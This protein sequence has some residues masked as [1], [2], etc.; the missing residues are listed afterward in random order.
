VVS[1]VSNLRP[2]LCLITTI[3]VGAV[4]FRWLAKSVRHKSDRSE[5]NDWKLATRIRAMFQALS[6]LII[7]SL[8]MH[9]LVQPRKFIKH[10]LASSRRCDSRDQG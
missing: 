10:L 9:R 3:H 8:Y 4:S 5:K 2:S 6:I 7:R 1:S